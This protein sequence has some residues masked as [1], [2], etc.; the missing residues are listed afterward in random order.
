MSTGPKK[1]LN[2]LWRVLKIIA[3]SLGALVAL[4][5]GLAVG[6]ILNLDA[7]FARRFVMKELNGILGTQFKGK[8]SIDRLAFLS[9]VG[10]GG[11]DA[12]ITAADG[13]KVVT[14]KGVSGRIS[15]I[16]IVKSALFGKG[17]ILIGIRSV[18]VDAVDVDLDTDAEGSLKLVK[19]FDPAKPS[20]PS[21]P[22][23]RRIAIDLEN[24]AVTHVWAHGTMSGAPPID[25]DVDAL[26]GSFLSTSRTTKLDVARVTLV[27]RGLPD[28][29]GVRAQVEG[30][31]VLPAAAGANMTVHGKLAGAVGVIPLTA[32]VSMNGDAV[33]G[34]LDVPLVPAVSVRTSIEDA[35]VYQSVSAHAE[36]HGELASL[37]VGLAAQLGPGS[38]TL[39]G[40]IHAKAP[41]GGTVTLA[42]RHLDART[43]MKAGPATDLGASVVAK[44]ET[45]ADGVLAAEATVETPQGTA[46]GQAVP[47]AALRLSATQ[48]PTKDATPSV[49]R[50]HVEGII[51]EPGA[52]IALTADGS[53]SD[54]KA[55]VSFGVKA[56]VP[57]LEEVKRI[58]NV[59]RGSMEVTVSGHADVGDETSFDA[60][61]IGKGH[62]LA[63]P[64]V[65]VDS[66]SLAARAHGT[67][68]SPEMQALLTADGI[69]ASGYRFARAEVLVSGTPAKAHVAASGRGEGDRLSDV[70][71]R[72]DVSFA[73]GVHVSDLS[74][75]LRRNGKAIE[76][77]IASVG[78]EG[79]TV[80]AEGISISGA[81]APLSASVHVSSGNVVF[82]ASTP[83]L[84]L[85]TLAYLAGQ[86][87]G[88]GTLALD[89]DLDAQRDRA[90]GKISLDLTKGEWSN[91][92]DGEAHL[93]MALDGRHLTGKLH[94]AL[95]TVGSFDLSNVDVHVGGRGPLEA[96]AWKAAWGTV[97]LAGTVD[98]AS[99]LALAPEDSIPLTDVAGRVTLS[100][101]LARDSLSDTTPEIRLSLATVGLAATGESTRPVR[102]PGGPLMVGPAT[103][104]L[105]DIDAR[106]DLAIDGADS[107]GEL[108][109]R[110]VDKKGA[111][112][113]V[114]LKTAPLPFKQLFA[115]EKDLVALMETL[116]VSFLI[117]VPTRELATLPLIVRPD[118]VRGSLSGM[119]SMKGTAEQPVVDVAL[120]GDKLVVS[121]APDTPM[122]GKVSAHYDGADAQVKASVS[123]RAVSVLSAEADLGIRASDVL[124]AKGLPAAWVG[125]VSAKLAC[126]PLAAIGVLSDN[127]VK[128]FVS[129]D[130]SVTGLHQH[131]KAA[132]NLAVDDL[133]MGKATFTK[134]G[135][136][137]SLDDKGLSGKVRLDDPR[138]FLE[139]TA[140]MGMKWDD[141]VVPVSDG[142]GL[143][144]KLSAKHF[145]VAAAAP[146]VSGALSELSGWI[147]ADATVALLPGRKPKMSGAVSFS[148]G[149]I[150][151][152]AIGE[153]FHAVKAKVALSQDGMVKLED[154]EGRGLSG[155]FT[156]SGSAHLDGTALLEADLLLEIPKKEAIPLDIQGTNLGTVFGKVTVKATGAPD[157]K[158]ITVAVNVPN[159]HVDLPSGSLPRSPQG[160]ADAASVH[161]G[162]Y[163]NPDRFIVL[164]LDGAPVKL[165][166]E[167]NQAVA[168]L[169]EHHADGDRPTLVAPPSGQAEARKEADKNAT[170]STEIDAKIHLGDVQ[171][172]R[173]QQLTINLDGDLTAKVAAA[174]TVRGEIHL[175]SGKLNVQSKEFDIEKGTVSFVGD[176]PSNPEVTVTAAWTAPDGTKVLADYVGPVKTGKVNLHSEPARPKSEIVELILFGTADGSQATPY[177]SRS[178]GTG[179]EA[180]TAI[181]GLTT[182]GL[183]K[184]LD[185]L[186]GMN[187]TTKVDTS[188]S[189]SPRAD[190]EFQIAKDISLQLAYVILQPP[191]G[192]NPDQVYATIDWRFLRNWS[193]QTTFGDAGSTFADFIWQYRY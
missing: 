81:G 63:H 132:L 40:L 70:S 149:V 98:A 188:D 31:L 193:L 128:G 39:G 185:Q 187:V 154:V 73:T 131:A 178:P 152:P 85:G 177:A 190:V 102:E 30:G 113:G 15:P 1:K 62:A 119:V 8:V 179:T 127:K 117:D 32:N 90:K 34:A 129:G 28:H 88:G 27:A 162:V 36:A 89:V 118:G 9:I 20:P 182:D 41:L 139:A 38:V 84:D 155:R 136:L 144:A 165:V 18:S 48:G 44:V 55:A 22:G 86:D 163:S 137:A 46:A 74:V 168:P 171:I 68:A 16:A 169:P 35:P 133:R 105:R 170:P 125:N 192:D 10:V 130:L 166:A 164:P 116:P 109:V 108:V 60:E 45:R 92:H 26:E 96:S 126:F 122:D 54:G 101:T 138:G 112:A 107:R 65:H 181:G 106:V 6:V 56:D 156:A 167:R 173:G 153:E 100:G 145:S 103:W 19:A 52:P 99:V 4:V 97:S 82:K 120:T 135:V 79:R 14:A 175:K 12:T 49:I 5:L 2:T 134:A 78:L 69:A 83:G 51:R 58:G 180:G 91:V 150:Q 142:S 33:D 141:A 17:D 24:I 191:P 159:F 148:E 42:A 77:R 50:A 25:A 64:G 157:G 3:G 158:N 143:H 71:V 124:L 7:P 140:S 115:G 72:G 184:G 189:S 80:D 23:S 13:S 21:P 67:P 94:A 147:D 66:F 114:D 183:S 123:S 160:L 161:I 186:T 146:F 172:L 121:A 47:P 11:V 29:I 176:D 43:F 95:G 76:A 174:T 110:L 57:R 111:L 151:A 104:N 59:G 61:I 93:A 75:G 87:K 53:S 37:K